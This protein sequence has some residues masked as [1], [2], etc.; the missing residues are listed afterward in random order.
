MNVEPSFGVHKMRVLLCTDGLPPFVL[1][2]PLSLL[3]SR[4]ISEYFRNTF[5]VSDTQPSPDYVAYAAGEHSS[6]K[7]GSHLVCKLHT[8]LQKTW[9][10]TPTHRAKRRTTPDSTNGTFEHA[11]AAG[12]N[13]DTVDAVP[14]SASRKRKLYKGRPKPQNGP[15]VDPKNS[16][17]PRT[18]IQRAKPT[19]RGDLAHAAA[20]V[21]NTSTLGTPRG[22]GP[23]S[24]G[25]SRLATGGR[26]GSN[27]NLPPRVFDSPLIRSPA[28]LRR[29]PCIPRQQQQ[30]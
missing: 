19:P 14:H 23:S 15:C 10:N 16:G 17:K 2:L 30:E 7:R 26:Q 9:E 13:P 29:P 18:K 21:V 4:G 3:L 11:A 28:G 24:H 12:C 6:N 25:Q 22:Q 5:D 20:I 8:Y 1:C 27:E